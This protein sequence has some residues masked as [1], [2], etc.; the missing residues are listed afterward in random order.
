MGVEIGSV[1]FGRVS[2]SRPER[3]NGFFGFASPVGASDCFPRFADGSEPPRSDTPLSRANS[4]RRR[5]YAVQVGLLRPACVFDAEQSVV[6]GDVPCESWG[7][8]LCAG[9]F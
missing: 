1:D 6:F 5:V 4:S 2:S 8:V 7:C 9:E 3:R